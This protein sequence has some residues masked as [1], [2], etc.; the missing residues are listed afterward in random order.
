MYLY[1]FCTWKN[2]PSTNQVQVPIKIGQN[3]FKYA[4]S[5]KDRGSWL[6]KTGQVYNFTQIFH[7][8]MQNSH[9]VLPRRLLHDVLLLVFGKKYDIFDVFSCILGI[10]LCIYLCT[11]F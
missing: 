9:L 3:S 7:V 8:T 5:G 1:V 2:E 10:Y 4:P 6:Q 11:W